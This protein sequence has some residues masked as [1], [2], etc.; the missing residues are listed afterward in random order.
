MGKSDTSIQSKPV[1]SESNLVQS[2]STEK[3]SKVTEVDSTYAQG[4]VSITSDFLLAKIKLIPPK[5]VEKRVTEQ[6][7]VNMLIESGVTHGIKTESISRLVKYPIY[8]KKFKVA[9]GVEPTPGKDGELKFYFNYENN[10]VPQLLEDGSVDYKNLGFGNDVKEGDLLCEVIKAVKGTDGIDVLGR[11]VISP[12]GKELPPPNGSNTRLSEDG[13]KLFANCD[14][15]VSVKGHKVNIHRVM[16]VDHVDKATGNILFSGDVTV[17]GDVND[18]FTIRAGGNI[19]VKGVVENAILVAGRDLLISKG[20]K[21]KDALVSAGGNLRVGYIESA[22]VKVKESIFADAVLHADIECG[23][24]VILSGRRGCLI[25]G[26]CRIT[27]ELQVKE[28]GNEANIFTEIIITAPIAADLQR[29]ALI[30]SIK[31]SN[32]KIERFTDLI[33]NST[34]AKM[35]SDERQETTLRALA[36]KKAAEAEFRSSTAQLEELNANIE[37]EY[38]GRVLLHGHMFP[39]VSLTI[40]GLLLKNTVMRP[41]C[42]I[43]RKKDNIAFGNHIG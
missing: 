20:I 14:G 26:I 32:E 13:A 10:L 9:Q 40:G 39:N 4:V 5:E 23:N 29:D 31:Q 1:L 3:K 36:A 43:M 2:N 16:V 34:Q 37:F 27:H 15:H 22:K 33:R 24:K 7:I 8:N 42:T 28:V 35:S 41:A 17:N 25:G 21:G 18:G 38:E 11:I 30:E 12:N 6:D 19:T